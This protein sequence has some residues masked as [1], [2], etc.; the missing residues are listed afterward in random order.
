MTN[1]LLDTSGLPRLPDNF[2]NH[3]SS[4]LDPYKDYKKQD[5][6][7]YLKTC[8]LKRRTLLSKPVTLKR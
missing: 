1:P 6:F 4:S 3:S 8:K 2:D 7:A 5:L